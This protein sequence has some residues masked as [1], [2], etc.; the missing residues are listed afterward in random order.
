MESPLAMLGWLIFAWGVGIIAIAS[1][2]STARVRSPTRRVA[3]VLG[4]C[5]F[6]IAALSAI[7]GDISSRTRIGLLIA[8][9]V[10]ALVSWG[11]GRRARAVDHVASRQR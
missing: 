10:V 11:L 7:L 6:C 9:G 4:G 8:A 1:F 2:A 5:V 3:D